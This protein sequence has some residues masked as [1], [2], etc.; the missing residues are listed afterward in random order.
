RTREL[1]YKTESIV[2]ELMYGCGL[3]SSVTHCT[4]NSNLLRLNTDKTK[5]M[6]SVRSTFPMLSNDK[7]GIAY[8]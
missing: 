1:A 7:K 8:Q 4:P 5:S 3:R 2:A 6:A